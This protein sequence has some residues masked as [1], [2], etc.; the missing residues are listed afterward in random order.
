MAYIRKI[1]RKKGIAYKAEVL[2]SDGSKRSRSFRTRDEAKAWSRA[3]EDMKS[4]QKSFGI[5]PVRM[6][7]GEFFEKFFEEYAMV[8]HSEGWRST[9]RLMFQK[10]LNPILGRRLLRDIHPVDI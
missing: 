3:Q 4:N 5:T 10:Y 2:L 8:H 9:D 1:S 7:F 6:T